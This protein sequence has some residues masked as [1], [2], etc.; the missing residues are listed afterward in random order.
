[1]DAVDMISG[2]LLFV[3]HLR[4]YNKQVHQAVGLAPLLVD[5]LLAADHEALSRLHAQV[6]EVRRDADRIKR[7]L[8]GQFK[9]M[10]FRPA[11]EYALGQYINSLDKV[12]ESAE[13]F[14]EA[15]VE[16]GRAHV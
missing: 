4:D 10:H 2:P 12:A 7:S 3:E 9:E 8:Y 6:S 14:A 11:G 16:I 15:I 1:M 5:A 13:A